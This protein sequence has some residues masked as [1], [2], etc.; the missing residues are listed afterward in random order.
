MAT[1]LRL[2]SLVG[3]GFTTVP[4]PG[5]FRGG[6]GAP[7]VPGQ[8]PGG[9]PGSSAYVFGGTG[10][11]GGGG[12]P[13][14]D[15]NGQ[16]LG[17]PGATYGDLRGALQ[18]GSGGAGGRN[19]SVGGATQSG[20]SGGGALE[21]SAA[22]TLRIDATVS[23]NGL[24]TSAFIYGPVPGAGSGGGIRLS[25]E[26]VVINGAVSANGDSVVSSNG[27]LHHQSASSG[28]RVLVAR[29]ATDYYSGSTLPLIGGITVAPGQHTTPSDT[30]HP[31]QHGQITYEYERIVV[32]PA[33]PIEFAASIVVQTNSE[34]QPG[35]EVFYSDVAVLNLG[36]ASVP[37]GGW[38][39]S[40]QIELRGPLARILGVDPL[41]NQNE[42]RGTGRVEVEFTNDSGGQINA[43]ND[44]LT[45]TKTVANNAGGQINAI[46]STLD[47]QDGLINNGQLNLI[48]STVDGAVMNGSDVALAGINTFTGAVSGPGNFTGG[49]EVF[50]GG[51]YSPGASTAE[52]SFDGNVVLADTNT[53]F[54]EIGGTT[55]GDDYDGLTIA[56]A[57]ELDGL[58]SVSLDG[59]TPSIGQQFTVLTASS[60]TDHGLML[61]G[62]AANSFSMMISG[63]SVILQAIGLAGDYNGDGTVNAADYTVWR[64]HSGQAFSL[65]NE[66]PGPTTPGFVDAEDYAFWKSQFGSSLFAS[67]A[68]S[69]SSLGAPIPEPPALFLL[70]EFAT[71]AILYAQRRRRPSTRF[72]PVA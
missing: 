30:F 1:N 55:L 43:V 71:L 24:F 3:G 66:K 53:L 21:L 2:D 57:A 44:E 12:A 14:L 23:A 72:S 18:G 36:E 6:T 47:F 38:T 9:G 19:L 54:I 31:G 26:D 48:N 50:L 49:G 69:D 59:F 33:T 15:M 67:G 25:G 34:T 45:F 7:P 32:T 40:H 8:G 16:S 10:G 4:G 22:K 37:A 61:G 70:P 52:V 35:L 68:N 28:G 56:G 39:N 63:T 27:T 41:V 58:L 11:F 46:N 64:N 5:G 51:S 60:I 13:A 29:R 17:A 62:P 65:P 42:L 20:G